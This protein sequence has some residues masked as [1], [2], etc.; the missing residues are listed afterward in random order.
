MTWKEKQTITILLSILGALS[1]ILL[2]VLGIRYRESRPA[3]VGSSGGAGG[4][5][6]SGSAVTD[7]AG[8]TGLSYSNGSATLT[9]S[10]DD[11]GAWIWSDDPGFP[12]NSA[13]ITAITELAVNP[14]FQQTLSNTESLD[15]YQL[16]NPKATL[17]LTSGESG[18]RTFAFGK[19][20][21]D[22]NSRYL[23]LDGVESTLYIMDG[24]LYQ[25]LQTPIY[26]MME[27]PELPDLSENNLRSLTIYGPQPEV[28]EDASGE[29]EES[30]AEEGAESAA[31]P[32][33]VPAASFT[34]KQ[35]DGDSAALWFSDTLNVTTNSALLELL[36]DLRGLSMTRC[37]DYRPSEEAEAICGFDAP[38]AVL[39]AEY[40]TESAGGQFT[41]TIGKSQPDGAGRYVQLGEEDSTVY[42][43]PEE[44]VDGILQIASNGID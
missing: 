2:V 25:Y 19:A 35:G 29:G 7:P 10:L 41:L 22:G 11:K 5:A 3:A 18:T 42:L 4:S 38:L 40:G 26:N 43:V 17:T 15:T 28:P 1:A 31:E 34:A 21:T 6:V 39:E 20:T 13:T 27:L 16:D 36:A 30:S 32:E 8:L 33:A 24:T 14:Q 37:V 23:M 12:L 9:F 44:S